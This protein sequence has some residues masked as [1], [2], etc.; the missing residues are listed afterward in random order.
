MP[1][2]HI[3]SLPQKDPS[4]VAPALKKTILA[5]SEF[6]GCDAKHVWATWEVLGAG[7]YLEGSCDALEQ[8]KSTHP[9]ICELTC[10]EG[11][12][13]SEIEKLLEITAGTLSRELGIEGNIFMIY[14]EAKS[15]KVI[16]GN[17]IIRK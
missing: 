8:P 1:I 17:G 7:Q 15:G 4:K 11:S 10:F 9:P 3:K 12:T 2:L 16:A 13:D 5:I 6:V 14:K